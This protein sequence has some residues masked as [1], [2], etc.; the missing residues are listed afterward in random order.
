MTLIKTDERS[1]FLDHGRRHH[2]QHDSAFGS[3][4]WYAAAVFP[5]LDRAFSLSR[6]ARGTDDVDDAIPAD[7]RDKL[8]RLLTRAA[9]KP[10]DVI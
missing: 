10:G 5:L 6:A 7:P 9:K 1:S 8:Q 3:M 4:R 2:N